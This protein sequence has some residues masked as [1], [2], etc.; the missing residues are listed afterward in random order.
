MVR[1]NRGRGRATTRTNGHKIIGS[2]G[3]G[4]AGERR[5]LLC[6]PSTQPRLVGGAPTH[7]PTLSLSQSYPTEPMD[8]RR[9]G[10][11]F[12]PHTFYFLRVERCKNRGLCEFLISLALSF[13]DRRSD[14]V[15]HRI[16]RIT[17]LLG[18]CCWDA[19]LGSDW[20]GYKFTFFKA[21]CC[22][23]SG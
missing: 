10:R 19:D 9:R 13:L 4:T 3:T 23:R 5:S 22:Y 18:L 15:L 2:R 14:T 12:K 17:L 16:A 20:E 6:F 1:S 21:S 7:T 8:R 11:R